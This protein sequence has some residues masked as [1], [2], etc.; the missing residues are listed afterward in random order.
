MFHPGHV[1]RIS[2]I[3]YDTG[4]VIYNMGKY[5]G[6]TG[7]TDFG[8]GLFY[9]QH[10]PQILSNGNMVVYDNGVLHNP[11]HT[12]A[13][14]L[15]FSPDHLD[16]TSASIVWEYDLVDD[17]DNLLYCSAWGSAVRTAGNH[18]LITGGLY[19]ELYEVDENEELVWKMKIHEIA[20][21]G[22]YRAEHIYS[23]IHDHP[24]DTDGDSDIDMADFANM[25]VGYTGPG[26]AIL[27]FPYTLSDFDHDSDIDLEDLYELLYWMTGPGITPQ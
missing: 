8:H 22:F 20:D 17:D 5:W 16:P 13:I 11:K 10:A 19:N 15:E 4:D 27:Q 14:E 18:T 12:R 3:D 26:P 23:L 1:S 24:G 9:L 7:G 21:V 2:C 6:G 25:V